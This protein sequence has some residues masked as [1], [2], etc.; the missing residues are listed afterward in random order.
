MRKLH[1]TKHEHIDI[2]FV[3]GLAVCFVITM[4]IIH[5]VLLY[6][7]KHT[8]NTLLEERTV[9][10]GI[11]FNKQAFEG[12]HISGKAYVVYDLLNGTVIAAQNENVSLPLASI[13]KVMTAVSAMLHT[14]GSKKVVINP[15][16]IEDGYDLGLKNNQ[17]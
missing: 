3:Y 11:V 1:H 13:T 17:V 9:T 16:D 5:Q 2:F 15:R 10:G 12:V 6:Q 8:V 7:K 14:D 4:S